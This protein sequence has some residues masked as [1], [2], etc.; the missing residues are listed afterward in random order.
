MRVRVRVEME[1]AN[2]AQQRVGVG[3]ESE[4]L[5][6]GSSTPTCPAQWRGCA[7][8][9]Y[10]SSSCFNLA[11]AP[12]LPICPSQPP[13]QP[14]HPLSQL[15]SHRGGWPWPTTP[16]KMEKEVHAAKILN[17]QS[18]QPCHKDIC[19]AVVGFQPK[20]LEKL[21]V[22]Q[23]GARVEGDRQDGE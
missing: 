15:R 22:P 4:R 19:A 2:A 5:S 18:L 12:Q 23:L 17:V 1:G 7:A 14:T 13:V 9:L 16:T 10:S 20:L 3:V 8:T 21:R 6:V 11:R